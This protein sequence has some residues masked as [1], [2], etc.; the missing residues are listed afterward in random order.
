MSAVAARY[1]KVYL[2]EQPSG[3]LLLPQT[4]AVPEGYQKD[5]AFKKFPFVLYKKSRTN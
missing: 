5:L 3:L 4:D 1:G 2:T